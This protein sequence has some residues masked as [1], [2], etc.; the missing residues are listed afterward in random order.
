MNSE[1]SINF[2]GNVS[3]VETSRKCTEEGKK[4]RKLLTKGSASDIDDISTSR[5]QVSPAEN[6]TEM[7]L[8]KFLKPRVKSAGLGSMMRDEALGQMAR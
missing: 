7:I 6:P 1:V 3:Q 4:L 5:H 2:Q 8:K